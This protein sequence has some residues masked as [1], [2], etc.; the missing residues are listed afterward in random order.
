MAFTR[1]PLLSL[2]IFKNCLIKATL[3]NKLHL[4]DIY[5]HLPGS[6]EFSV[7]EK[8]KNILYVFRTPG[9]F[10]VW[11]GFFSTSGVNVV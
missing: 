7:L 3:V 10:N 1:N 8:N 6:A 4:L 2:C 9:I 5:L 11:L